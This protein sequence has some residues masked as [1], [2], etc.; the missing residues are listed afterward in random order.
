MFDMIK[1]ADPFR[2]TFDDLVRSKIGF[3]FVGNMTD[4]RAFKTYENRE[5]YATGHFDV[6][7]SG[8]GSDSGW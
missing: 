8:Q 5:A 3:Y 6:G 1:P 2:I 4:V 7:A